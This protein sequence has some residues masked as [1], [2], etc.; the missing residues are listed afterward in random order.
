[1]NEDVFVVVRANGERT[2]RVSLKLV[3]YQVPK[4]NILVIN[5]TPFSKAVK[6]TFQKGIEANQKW[7]LA[8][9]ADVLLKTGAIKELINRAE[10]LP[11]NFFM[12]QGR[13]LDKFFCFGR[14]GGPHL[15]RTDLLKIAIN[16]IPN[17]EKV[18]ILSI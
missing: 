2:T 7:T 18:F 5:E 3:S 13:V 17:S 10:S 9:D 15:F 1:M 12:I 6:T 8:L 16:K 4:D 11:Q 14:N